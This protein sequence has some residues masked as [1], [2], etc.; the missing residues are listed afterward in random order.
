LVY[1][2]LINELAMSQ[3]V[4]AVH[5]VEAATAKVPFC[6][7]LLLDHA[8]RKT[9]PEGI[10]VRM[11]IPSA[12]LTSFSLWDCED[13]AVLKAWLDENLGV[14]C[15]TELAEV[16]EEFTYG[17]A[18]ELASARATEKVATSGL[19]TIGALGEKT[20][21]AAGMVA[22]GV[23]TAVEST[24][25]RLEEWDKRT[26]VLTTAK[27]TTAATYSR[28]AEVVAKAAENE[29]VQGVMS[30]VHQ[31]VSTGWLKV[32]KWVGA[33]LGE[34]GPPHPG[35]PAAEGH[36]PHVFQHSQFN[37]SGD[38]MERPLSSMGDADISYEPQSQQYFSGGSTA[39]PQAHTRTAAVHTLG[40]EGGDAAPAAA[41][42]GRTS[43][44]S[45]GLTTEQQ[46]AALTPAAATTGAQ[47]AT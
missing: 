3:L 41:A 4:L 34:P 29:K 24:A 10:R 40:S 13:P 18:M 28:M 8:K 11:I 22:A 27:A 32:S 5:T 21:R 9:I 31:G 7:I 15:Q 35:G 20:H 2:R 6:M 45:G 42:P 25:L 30:N 44:P 1:E 36:S 46:P 39:D 47:P 26:G 33:R 17:I 19:K 38:G 16:E 14:D 37:Y 43:F 12:G 23:N